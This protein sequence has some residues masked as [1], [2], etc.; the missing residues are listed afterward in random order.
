MFK[1]I[2]LSSAL[3]TAAVA[4]PSTGRKSE[5]VSVTTD[6]LG[7]HWVRVLTAE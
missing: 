1:F 7:V 5:L 4:V 2:A 3:F 6:G